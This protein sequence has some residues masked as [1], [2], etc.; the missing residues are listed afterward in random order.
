MNVERKRK[1]LFGT[2]KILS[3]KAGTAVLNNPSKIPT[4][5]TCSRK[6]TNNKFLFS[7]IIISWKLENNKYRLDEMELN[8]NFFFRYG[9]HIT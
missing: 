1:E 7:D 2:L 9:W 5:I 4:N 8:R 3:D 6:F